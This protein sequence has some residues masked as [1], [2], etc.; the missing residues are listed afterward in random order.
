VLESRRGEPVTAS[1]LETLRAELAAGDVA[2]EAGSDSADAGPWWR[3]LGELLEEWREES[4]DGALGAGTAREFLYEA[5]VERGREPAIGDGVRLA[6]V[7]AAKGLELRHLF[8]ADGGWEIGPETPAEKAEEERRLYYVGVTRAQETLHLLRRRDRHNP[9]LEALDGDHPFLERREPPVEPPAGGVAGRRYAPLGLHDLFLSYAGRFAPDHPIHRRIAA[10]RPGDP[11]RFDPDLD[12]GHL[13]LVD[14]RGG[15]VAAL[16]AAG[17][18]R[19]LDRLGRVETI[20]VLAL[21]ERRAEDS[22]PEHRRNLRAERWW[23]PVA[24]VIHRRR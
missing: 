10:L 9:H 6:T 15:R 3:L 5:L 17:R 2:A 16:S 12:R 23:V 13:H 21:A 4:A 24:E 1:E 7:H 11:L 14:D 20:R 22:P 18:E 8:L 19:W